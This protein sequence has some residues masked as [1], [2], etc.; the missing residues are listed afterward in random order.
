MARG[1]EREV[2]W[3]RPNDRAEGLRFDLVNRR[4]VKSANSEDA[5]SP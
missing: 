1:P 4:K 5:R 3:E 2:R